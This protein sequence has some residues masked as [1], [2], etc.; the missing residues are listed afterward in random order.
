[1]PT[2]IIRDYLSTIY[3]LNKAL[4]ILT[5]GSSWSPQ[6]S[7][8]GAMLLLHPESLS[9]VQAMASWRKVSQNAT[10]MESESTV[11][12]QGLLIISLPG[13]D[14]LSSFSYVPKFMKK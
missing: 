2:E 1:M 3:F 5:Q 11:G 12:T 7:S 4:D 14:C 6:R 10:D 8:L 9:V 13:S